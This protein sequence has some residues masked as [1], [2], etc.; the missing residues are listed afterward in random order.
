MAISPQRH[1]RSTYIRARAVIFA[2][3]QLS[4]YCIC[5]SV[6][7]SLC[8]CI[9]FSAFVANKLHHNNYI[10]WWASKTECL[11]RTTWVHDNERIVMMTGR[12]STAIRNTSR[13][14]S[15][16][17][18]QQLDH[19]RRMNKCHTNLWRFSSTAAWGQRR[20]RNVSKIIRHC[21]RVPSTNLCNEGR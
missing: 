17:K 2:I 4:C 5:L 16:A 6:C 9:S 1:I 15:T 19:T 7:L 3:A 13:L 20:H 12:R 8:H 10:T 18:Q 14:T 11:R 21:A